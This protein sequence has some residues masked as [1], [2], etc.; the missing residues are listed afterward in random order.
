METVEVES[1]STSL[2]DIIEN[3]RIEVC[4]NLCKFRDSCDDDFV[5]DYVRENGYCPLDRL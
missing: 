5:C 3:V 2:C 1:I 4:T